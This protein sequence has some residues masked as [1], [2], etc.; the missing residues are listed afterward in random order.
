V[1]VVVAPAAVMAVNRKKVKWTGR[2]LIGLVAYVQHQQSRKLFTS[3]FLS[4]RF[5]PSQ[6]RPSKSADWTATKGKIQ[7]I[8]VKEKAVT[9]NY[10]SGDFRLPISLLPPLL[11]VFV[12]FGFDPCDHAT[13]VNAHRPRPPHSRGNNEIASLKIRLKRYAGNESKENS[14]GLLWRQSQQVS[15][16]GKLPSRHVFFIPSFKHIHVSSRLIRFRLRLLSFAYFLTN[17]LPTN[18][19]CLIIQDSL[20]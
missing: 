8:N 19:E 7:R 3:T 1:G 18:Q 16:G 4:E 12:S 13:E 17:Y 15:T 14:S 10:S 6:Q 9:W 11:P 2:Y 5:A 20:F